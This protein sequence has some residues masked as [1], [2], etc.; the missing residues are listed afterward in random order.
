V[1]PL[2]E[3]FVGDVR[4]ALWVLLGAVGFLL[5]IACANVA[6]L[7]LARATTRRK[8]IALR[9]ALGAGR[10]RVVR[11]LLAERLLLAGAGGLL[12]L[13]LAAWGVGLL[14]G[15]NPE[16]LPRVESISLDARAL[17]FTL[18]VTLLTGVVFGLAP[19]LQTSKVDFHDA[20]KEGGPGAAGGAR[21]RLRG[22][23]VVTQVALS[24]VRLVGA[25]LL[26]KSFWRLSRV[27]PGFDAHNVLTRRLRLPDA[28]YREAAQ[29]F[30]FLDEVARRVGTLP[31]V[32]RVSLTTGFPLGR[33]AENGYRVE[34]EPEPRRPGEW[35]VANTQSVDENYHQTLGIALLAG[36]H[37]TAGD[38][39]DSPPV[40]IVDDEFVRRHF[41]E[42]PPG[43][44][45]GKRLR[46]GGEGEP[47]RAVVGVV[48]HV[49]QNGP[50]QEGHAGIYRPWTQLNPKW[51]ADYARAMDLV[52][53]ASGEPTNLIAPIRR[54]VQAA[55]KDQPLGNV[56]TLEA[57]AERS[58]AP[59]RFTLLLVGVFAAVALLLGAV[60]LYGVL[61]YVVTQRTR[62]IGIRMALGAQRR[63][64]LR[65]IAGEGMMLALAG[66]AVGL[67]GAFALTRLMRGLLFGV[68]ATDPLTFVSVALLLLAV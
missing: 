23:F 33:A 59:R 46:F 35:P 32:R 58:V 64:V 15:L 3:Q 12:G 6:N 39:A 53:K 48:R 34:G 63:D 20:L 57:L 42:G 25:G 30:A 21:G 67:V 36:R 5:L 28:K 31:G 9:M 22:A 7:L 55:D 4:P 38:T 26:V 11:Q 68:T 37:F 2:R 10:R 40:V 27:D 29:A 52:V 19:A 18:L 16:A 43:G 44:A 24:L 14:I 62:E 49:R 61:S 13:T 47:W 56:R 50:G 41:P 8:E 1:I 60:G 66:V 51:A 17:G 54:E 65:L 45:L